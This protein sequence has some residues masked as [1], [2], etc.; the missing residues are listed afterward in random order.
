MGSSF[1]IGNKQVSSGELHEKQASGD[2]PR[3]QAATVPEAKLAL[4]A[5]D[6]TKA[7]VPAATDPTPAFTPIGM[8]I[9]RR[10]RRACR[11]PWRRPIDA[12]APGG[13]GS[14]PRSSSCP[15]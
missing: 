10:R 2:L 12:T 1:V 4:S 5:G 9:T 13:A 7:E 15:I 8:T 14:G 11:A 6:V 3:F